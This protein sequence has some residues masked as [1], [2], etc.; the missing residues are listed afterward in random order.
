[1]SRGEYYTKREKKI[2]RTFTNNLITVFIKIELI[3]G[4]DNWGHVVA[5]VC[6]KLKFKDIKIAVGINQDCPK[7][8][9]KLPQKDHDEK[10]GKK[11][12]ARPSHSIR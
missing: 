6:Y 5:M 11:L 10:V 3:R 2:I 7:E 8:M 1:M 4:W 9:V 12:F